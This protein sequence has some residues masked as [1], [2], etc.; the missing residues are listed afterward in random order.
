M[1]FMRRASIILFFVLFTGIASAASRGLSSSELIKNAGEYDGK[2]IIYSGEAIGDIMLR[3]ES[4]W[5]NVSDGDNALGIWMS[6]SLAKEINF[7][8]G[9]KNRGDSLEITGVF[10]RACPE[11]GGDLDIHAR[12]MRKLKAGGPISRGLDPGK[13]NAIIIL[14]GVLVLIWILTLFKHK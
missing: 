5:V 1:S 7:T 11:H 12:S 10:H 6:A 13:K 14:F 4:A 8:G 3:G 2:T 9:Y